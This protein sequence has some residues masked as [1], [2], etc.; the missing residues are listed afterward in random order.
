MNDVRTPRVAD[1]DQM[2]E[3]HEGL[4]RKAVSLIPMNRNDEGVFNDA[5]I[6]FQDAAYLCGLK[7]GALEHDEELLGAL[8]QAR[9]AIDSLFA[10][11]IIASPNF[12]P[13]KS[14][15]WPAMLAVNKAI[16]KATRSAA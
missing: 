14:V 12:Y 3:I 5:V 15:Q 1:M 11:L 10:A 6:P 16:A 2:I 8:R 9:G 4:V 13:S 7:R